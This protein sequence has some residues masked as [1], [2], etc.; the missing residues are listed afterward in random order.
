M[1]YSAILSSSPES[2]DRIRPIRKFAF[3]G[4][5]VKRRHDGTRH[6][7]RV[8]RLK[9]SA[10]PDER[11][12]RRE[13]GE[14]G[15]AVEKVVL[16]AENDAGP[17]NDGLRKCGQ[18][19]GLAFTLGA[20]V[21]GWSIAVRRERGDVYQRAGA[22][23]LGG[24]RDGGGAGGL[25]GAEFLLA[26]FGKDA[27]QIDDGIGTFGGAPHRGFVAD[28]GLYGVNLADAAEGLQVPGEIGTADGNA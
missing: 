23:I 18:H 21:C 19:G 28:I 24:L 12:Q 2:V 26:A 4:V 22:G 13:A 9:A 6:V 1:V 8:N 10:A 15:E 27:H 25:H 11:H 3:R 5:T 7:A 17:Q 16:G 14:A 20:R